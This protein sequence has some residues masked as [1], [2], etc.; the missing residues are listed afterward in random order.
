MQRPQ[1]S[2]CNVKVPLYM[3]EL[4]KQATNHCKSERDKQQVATLLYQYS[5]V[6]S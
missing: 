1:A 2:M 4:Y 6:F 3:K 5:D